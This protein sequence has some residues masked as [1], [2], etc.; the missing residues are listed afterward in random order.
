MVSSLDEENYTVAGNALYQGIVDIQ[1]KK[2]VE[3]FNNN[4]LDVLFSMYHEVL[5]HLFNDFRDVNKIRFIEV[6][7]SVVL[8]YEK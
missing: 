7:G 2:M 6:D 4:L 1:P 8:H 5:Y 3:S